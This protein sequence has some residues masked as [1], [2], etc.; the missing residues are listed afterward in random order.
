[1]KQDGSTENI[2][3]NLSFEQFKK[4]INIEKHIELERKFGLLWL[5]AGRIACI[6]VDV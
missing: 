1:L 3:Q 4:V 5:Y 2:N 6:H